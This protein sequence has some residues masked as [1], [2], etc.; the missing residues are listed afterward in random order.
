MS[1]RCPTRLPPWS[2]EPLKRNV[3]WSSGVGK[4]QL[5][6]SSPIKV[7]DMPHAH[8]RRTSI[9]CFL[10][11]L[12]VCVCVCACACVRVYMRACVCACVRA[13]VHVHHCVYGTRGR[14]AAH[15][16]GAPKKTPMAHWRSKTKNPPPK[17]SPPWHSGAVANSWRSPRGPVARPLNNSPPPQVYRRHIRLKDH[18]TYTFIYMWWIMI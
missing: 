2:L 15:P 5:N 6:K 3:S 17:K 16:L 12:C 8:A 1:S 7:N 4:H 10:T 11:K 9:A 14:G 18:V 13:C